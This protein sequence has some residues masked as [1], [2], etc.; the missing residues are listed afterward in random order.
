MFDRVDIRHML[1]QIA[2]FGISAYVGTVGLMYVGQRSLIFGTNT[3][4]GRKLLT[5]GFLP[6]AGSKRITIVT[7]DGERLAGWYARPQ[8]EKPVFLFLHGKGSGLAVMK[9]R[10]QRI[11]KTG[12]GVLAFSYRGYPGSTGR[13]SET[14]LIADAN[15]AFA[16]L[17][18][19]HKPDEIV[20]HGLSLGTG[21][22][23]ALAAN[24]RARALILEAPFTA[25]VD[26]AAERY[27]FLPVRWLMWDP[28]LS[29]ERIAHVRMPIMI[30]HGTG[31]T[32]IPYHHAERLFARAQEPK[33]LVTMPGSDHN[34]L[35]RDGLYA[36]I[37]RFLQ[38]DAGG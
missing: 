35:V 21:V 24:V 2:L 7:A 8:P 36:H 16:W 34:T 20:I 19:R 4:V 37:W 32:V 12:A 31:D 28:F 29:R 33:T 26:V 17:R 9:W 6:I 23:V 10:W 27:P 5:P 14:G 1:R 15:A 30:A 22:G 3:D 18:Q 25:V 38:H 11:R 13:P